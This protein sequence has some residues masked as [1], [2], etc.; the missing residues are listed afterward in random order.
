MHSRARGLI[1]LRFWLP[2]SFVSP[3]LVDVLQIFSA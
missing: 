2:C 3:W 1:E